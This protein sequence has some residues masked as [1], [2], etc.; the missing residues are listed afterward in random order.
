[1]WNRDKNVSSTERTEVHKLV[2]SNKL[3]EVKVLIQAELACFTQD[4]I[5]EQRDKFGNTPII[6]A[7]QQGHKR[8]CKLLTAA[9]CNVSASNTS[10]N[11]ALHYAHLYGHQEL[12]QYLVRKGGD[13][14]LCNRQGLAPPDMV[15]K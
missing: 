9:A 10:G 5:W 2:L 1:V 14:T 13:E 15:A 3:E 4:P 11:S 8:M 7:A 12:Y 6:V